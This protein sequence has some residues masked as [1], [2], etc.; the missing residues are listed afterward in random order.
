MFART[1]E[2]S[3]PHSSP[4]NGGR[5]CFLALIIVGGQLVCAQD[6][7]AISRRP[8]FPPA[9]NWSLAIDKLRVVDQQTPALPDEPE[10]TTLEP[11]KSIVRELSGDQKH[12]YQITLT[13]GQFGNVVVA[14]RGI[15]LIVQMVAADG[16]SIVDFDTEIRTQA[17]KK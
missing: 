10:V 8:R 6:G 11:G 2:R 12:G 16:K 7:W 14:Q 5:T 13:E 9:R 15:D 1:I 17:K 3:R 4:R